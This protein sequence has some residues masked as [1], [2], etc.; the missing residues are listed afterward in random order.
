MN[1]GIYGDSFVDSQWGD[2][3][4]QTSWPKELLHLLNCD[5][6]CYAVSGTSTW[7]SYEQFLD[8]YRSH[9]IIIFGYSLPGRWPVLPDQILGQHYNTSSLTGNIGKYNLIYNDIFNVTLF[10]F[11][12]SNIFKSINEICK[13]EGKYLINLSAREP[14]NYSSSVEFPIF[15]NLFNIAYGE[16]IIRNGEILNL[17]QLHI[18]ENMNDRRHCHLNNLNNKLLAT[19]F[20][21]AIEYRKTGI[22]MNLY[23]EA[24]WHEF[25]PMMQF[26]YGFSE[27]KII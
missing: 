18:D 6:K 24:P 3:S 21:D 10:Q 27:S 22:L 14:E 15:Y 25:D 13:K 1:I 8:T 12:E 7:W 2:V 11:I 9:D 19:I 17:S 23:K 26:I 5:G 4:K 16:K 20:K